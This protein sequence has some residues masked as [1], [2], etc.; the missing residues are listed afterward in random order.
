MNDEARSLWELARRVNYHKG[1]I[2]RAL[3]DLGEEDQDR[4]E[5]I[6]FSALKQLKG[7]SDSV[8]IY[9]MGTI[10]LFQPSNEEHFAT[11][12]RAQRRAKREAHRN[13]RLFAL[14]QLH[15]DP[16][17]AFRLLAN[18][19]RDSEKAGVPPSAGS[20]GES[21]TIPPSGWSRQAFEDLAE[22]LT[23][24]RDVEA[25]LDPENSLLKQS[26]GVSEDLAHPVGVA[27]RGVH[28]A[29]QV[30]WIRQLRMFFGEFCHKLRAVVKSLLHKR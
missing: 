10:P 5:G 7:S 2:T 26:Q 6:M 1:D 23:G 18:A 12:W 19:N 27:D 17:Q 29:L 11:V 30:S 8:S 14:S 24:V 22:S 15:H 4:I 9:G 16:V 13:L 21:L 3:S 28:D 25:F 20:S